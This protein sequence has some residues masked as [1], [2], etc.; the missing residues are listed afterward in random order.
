MFGKHFSP[1]PPF[2]G[3]CI[4]VVDNDERV[5]RVAHDILGRWGCTVETARDGREALTLAKLTRY[6]AV[7]AD[8]RLPDL[9][10]YDVY[11]Q[12]RA[13]QPNARVV[14]HRAVL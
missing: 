8:I 13:A 12:L 9:S 3:L 5:R 14:P 1:P 2:R 11:R 6:D 10:G 7:L 4:L